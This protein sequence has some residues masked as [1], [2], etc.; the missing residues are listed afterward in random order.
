MKKKERKKERKIDR[1]KKGNRKEKGTI[2]QFVLTQTDW[3]CLDE[4]IKSLQRN[5]PVFG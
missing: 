3:F 1:K 4:K 2:W 5:F